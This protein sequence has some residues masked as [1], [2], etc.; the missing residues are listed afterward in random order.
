MGRSPLWIEHAAEVESPVFMDSSPKSNGA[1][2]GA[3]GIPNTFYN[4]FGMQLFFKR[5]YIPKAKC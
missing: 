5:S 2:W 3:T 1:I 4:N